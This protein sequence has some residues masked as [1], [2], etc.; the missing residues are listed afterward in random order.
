M[1]EVLFK[2]KKKRIN[3]QIY[4]QSKSTTETVEQSAQS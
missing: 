1:P 4:A 2:K 3:K